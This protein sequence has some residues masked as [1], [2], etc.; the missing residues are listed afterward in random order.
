MLTVSKIWF[1]LQLTTFPRKAPSSLLQGK[2][3]LGQ[4]EGSDGPA[5]WCVDSQNATVSGPSP[6]LWQMGS[7]VSGSVS[8]E[9]TWSL[10]LLAIFVHVLI[11]L[12]FDDFI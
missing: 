5:V 7:N 10:F 11:Y 8:L 9:L 2:Y 3:F 1:S 6:F 4:R 12:F